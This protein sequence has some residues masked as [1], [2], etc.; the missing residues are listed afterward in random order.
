MHSGLCF[1]RGL[2]VGPETRQV[3]SPV[4]TI[5]KNHSER[6]TDEC[7]RS[8]CQRRTRRVQL[9][10]LVAQLAAPC[11]VMCLATSDIFGQRAGGVKIQ[12]Y[13]LQPSKWALQGS[14]AVGHGGGMVAG[15]TPPS[16]AINALHAVSR[17]LHN[18][19]RRWWPAAATPSST[20]SLEI[21][22]VRLLGAACRA[23][24]AC[25]SP[26]WNQRKKKK[27]NKTKQALR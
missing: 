19:N 3:L 10:I 18:R 6:R 20:R 24:R 11:T 7:A 23:C 15:S 1:R 25:T 8:D 26:S 21:I 16:P 17:W 9:R 22:G 5:S 27:K 13:M 4:H 12:H 2:R 14:T